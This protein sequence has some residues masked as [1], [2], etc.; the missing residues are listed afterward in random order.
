MVTGFYACNALLSH[1]LLGCSILPTTTVPGSPPL[2]SR[3]FGVGS[4]GF[5]LPGSALKIAPSWLGGTWDAW[6]RTRV[7]PGVAACEANAQRCAL[8][9]RCNTRQG[10]RVSGNSPSPSSAARGLATGSRRPA[11]CRHTAPRCRLAGAEGGEAARS[12]GKNTAAA[13]ESSPS[14]RRPAR[15]KARLSLRTRRRLPRP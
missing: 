6:D 7:R 8:S 9:T 13:Q 15:E 3:I 12:A 10:G 4:K 5:V 11:R 2:S 1:L 14:W